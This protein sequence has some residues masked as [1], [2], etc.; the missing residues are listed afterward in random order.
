MRPDG[1]VSDQFGCFNVH[2]TN[3]SE[4]EYRLH[5]AWFSFVASKVQHRHEFHGLWQVDVATTRRALAKL[6]RDDQA[7]CRLSLAG[8]LFTESYKSKWADQTADCPWCGQTD[9]RCHRYWECPQ[10]AD[11]RESLAP[12]VL[13]LLDSI[14]RHLPC[15]VGRCYPL[16]GLVGFV[17]R[18]VCRQTSLCPLVD[19]CRARGIM[20]SLMALAFTLLSRGIALPHGLLSLPLTVIDCGL[21]AGPPS[22]VPP[23]FRVCVKQPTAQNSLLL[24]MC[25]IGQLFSRRLWSFGQTVAVSC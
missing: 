2:T 5:W 6:S 24:R 1:L 8:S 3:F 7:L 16:L 13:P 11:L 25:Y 14:P 20:F 17:P 21:L 9:H 22:F 12:D 19:F 23:S 15:V 10:H 4:V 18:S